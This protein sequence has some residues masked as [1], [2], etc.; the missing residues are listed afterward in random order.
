MTEG[1]KIH[2]KEMYQEY[3]TLSE[4]TTLVA[5]NYVPGKPLKPQ[6]LDINELLKKEELRIKL[7]KTCRDYL[8]ECL[9]PEELFEM[10]NEES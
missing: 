9:T 4:R 5:Q 2:C 8:E 3:R 10:E 6:H 1:K 7:L